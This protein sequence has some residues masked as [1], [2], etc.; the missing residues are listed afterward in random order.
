MSILVTSTVS[1]PVASMLKAEQC[2]IDMK[3][4]LYIDFPVCYQVKQ[5]LSERIAHGA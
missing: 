3:A 5:R 4:K 1:D 2:G